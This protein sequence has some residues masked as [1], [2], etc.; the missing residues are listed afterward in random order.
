MITALGQSF[1]LSLFVK[2]KELKKIVFAILAESR[3]RSML[4]IFRG[5]L[6]HLARTTGT[7]CVPNPTSVAS[8][9]VNLARPFSIARP[10]FATSTT[11]HSSLKDPSLDEAQ[12]QLELGTAALEAGNV[13]DAKVSFKPTFTV[14]IF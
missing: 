4:Q 12:R 11:P 8:R 5:S 3:S 14:W 13:V 1:S 10:M 6:G 9:N 2:V 7:R